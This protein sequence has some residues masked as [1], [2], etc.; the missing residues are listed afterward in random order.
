MPPP[1]PAP[2]ILTAFLSTLY[3]A[4]LLAEE[5]CPIICH[6]VLASQAE[7]EAQAVTLTDFHLLRFAEPRPYSEQELRWLSPAVQQPSACSP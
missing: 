5:G 4:S 6:V 3:Q 1:L 2:D 7:L